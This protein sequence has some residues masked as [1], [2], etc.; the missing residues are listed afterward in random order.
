MF[1]T[2]TLTDIVLIIYS[3]TPNLA[4]NTPLIHQN[5][6]NTEQYI[7]VYLHYLQHP[8]Q[9]WPPV[10]N[11]LSPGGCWHWLVAGL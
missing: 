9:P 5:V 3:Q 11:V 6:S 7:M 1:F 2:A 8:P 10:V 4:Y